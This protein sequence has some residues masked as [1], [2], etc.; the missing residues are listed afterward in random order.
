ME[1]PKYQQLHS[2]NSSHEI[3]EFWVVPDE[4]ETLNRA[5]E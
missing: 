1:T 4:L 2:L 5:R 3:L